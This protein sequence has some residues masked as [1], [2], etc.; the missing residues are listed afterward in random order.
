MTENGIQSLLSTVRFYEAQANESKKS[1]GKKRT[2]PPVTPREDID[3]SVVEN[4]GSSD[5]MRQAFGK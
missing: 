1:K 5:A 2:L 3:N 4:I